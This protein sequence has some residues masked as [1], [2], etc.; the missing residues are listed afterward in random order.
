MEKDTKL[1]FGGMSTDPEMK[2][3]RERFGVPDP[4]LIPYS[5]I[6]EVISEKTQS[7]RF[8]TV[9]DR[10]RREL[11]RE[12]NVITEAEASEGIR[13]LTAAERV[14]FSA[15]HLR[16][17]TRH[18]VRT[19]NRTLTTP[20]EDLDDLQRR[21]LDHLRRWTERVGRT[22]IEAATSVRKALRAPEQLPRIEPLKSEAA[23][24]G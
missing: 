9:T 13:V 21:K 6:E 5:E 15:R 18:A 2:M 16:S 1:Y 22:A 11:E 14:D 20:T 8:R 17:I 4:G 3:L 23:K 12:H 24:E 7:N 19:H 10:W